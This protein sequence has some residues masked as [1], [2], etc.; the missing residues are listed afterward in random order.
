MLLVEIGS[1]AG[2]LHP[3]GLGKFGGRPSLW[4]RPHE[5][6]GGDQGGVD[7]PRAPTTASNPP[8]S[9]EGGLGQLL[10][11]GLKRNQ[12]CR[13]LGLRLGLPDCETTHFF[14]L[15]HLVGS[16]WQP[17]KYRCH[18][19]SL[20]SIDRKISNVYF[21]GLLLSQLSI[22]LMLIEKQNIAGLSLQIVPQD[23]GPQG[24]WNSLAYV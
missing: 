24:K 2:V 22:Y 8:R 19:S 10:R 5:D 23:C 16:I 15:S 9:W 21:H 18:L 6:G 20:R 11:H 1:F 17:S 13:H 12:A 4:E 14:G 7:K 3:I